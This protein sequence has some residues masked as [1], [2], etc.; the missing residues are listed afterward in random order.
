[1]FIGQNDVYEAFRS[2]AADKP[3]STVNVLDDMW[4]HLLEH[5]IEKSHKLYDNPPPPKDVTPEDD[6]FHMIT[7]SMQPF[8]TR[9]E[10][11]SN[12]IGNLKKSLVDFKGF[13]CV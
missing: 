7:Y 11:A 13:S 2:F 4:R 12:V 5:H 10:I 9:E 3:E 8:P 1:M 6:N